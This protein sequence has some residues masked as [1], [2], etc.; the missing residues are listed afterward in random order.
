MIIIVIDDWCHYCHSP[1][2][3]YG[4]MS[5][6]HIKTDV[7]VTLV[8]DDVISDWW[9]AKKS[10]QSICQLTQTTWDR[11]SRCE[12]LLL[13]FIAV[14][15]VSADISRW[16]TV[17]PWPSFTNP[18]TDPWCW[19]INGAPWIPWYP[20]TMLEYIYQHHGSGMGMGKFA[21]ASRAYRFSRHG[22]FRNFWA[23]LRF[24]AMKTGLQKFVW[25]CHQF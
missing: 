2:K 11:H 9:S 19:Y 23:S 25:T 22:A 10:G 13:V 3:T 7:D 8:I 17:E 18:M 5:L 14:A 20:L 24:E 21:T 4:L 1:K 6:K 16:N 12:R 15:A